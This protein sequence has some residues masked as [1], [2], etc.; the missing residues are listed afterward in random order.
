MLR[1]P[2]FA[3]Q[4]YPSEPKEI[5]RLIKSFLGDKEYPRKRALACLLPHAGYVYSGKVAA[6][7]LAGIEIPSR[8]IM[9]G[10]NHTG[11]G[12]QVSIMP[13]G[14]WRTPLGEVKIDEALAE[15]FLKE[16]KYLK[17]DTSAHSEEH[18]LE[19]ELPL[20]QFFRPEFKIVPIAFMT[21][22]L[23]TLKEVGFQIAQVIKS[24]LSGE[25]FLILASSDLTHYEP[26]EEAAEKDSSAINAIL[27]L[28]ADMLMHRIKEFNIS[29]CGFAPAI[30]MIS[31]AKDLG[32][33]EGKLIKYQTS[34][35]V[36]RDM[37]AV[38]GYAGI[39]L[40]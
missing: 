9:L 5:K 21:D 33:R 27:K 23:K 22:D 31:A 32:A 29:M 11:N 19:V 34:G 30:V 13:E 8:I 38:V 24:S 2:V 18:S 7:T 35:D 16:C 37:S 14:S 26:Q 36:N 25:D 6:L 39:T 20:L 12:E 4:F 28:D 17:A 40:N 3:G 1:R 15:T 10:P